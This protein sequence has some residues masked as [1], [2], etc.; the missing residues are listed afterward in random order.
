MIEVLA[1]MSRSLL[2]NTKLLNVSHT[3]ARALE[4]YRQGHLTDAERLYAS[5]LAVRPDHFDALH[6]LG[7]IKLAHG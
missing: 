1:D 4:L 3:L 2:P 7:M 6:R 5:I